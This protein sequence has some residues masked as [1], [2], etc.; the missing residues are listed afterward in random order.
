[1]KNPALPTVSR[2]TGK[3]WREKK[4]KSLVLFELDFTKCSLCGTCVRSAQKTHL[5]IP[6]NTTWRLLQRKRFTLTS[7]NGWR[8]GQNMTFYQIIAEGLFIAFIVLVILG[9]L[10]TI[11]AK[12][13]MQTILGLAQHFSALPVFIFI[14]GAR[15]SP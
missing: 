6:R 9:S 7:S 4:K 11:R 13:L 8:N 2:S 10:I 15:F 14:W 5:S 3:K 1:M 12:I